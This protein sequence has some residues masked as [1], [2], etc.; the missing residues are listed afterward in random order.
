MSQPTEAAVLDALRTVQDPDLHKDVVSLGFVQD[1][2]IQDG[3]VSFRLVLT[4]PA[5]PVKDQMRKQ[6]EEAV[7]S[8]PGVRK[9]T[10][11]MDS[12]VRSSLQPG[13]I[14]G[15]EVKNVI[16]VTSGKGGVGK[17]TVAVNLAAAL[18]SKGAR[19]GLLDADV[20]GP[21][22]PVMMGIHDKPRGAGNGKI[23][24]LVA[25]GI[26]TMSIGYL[27]EDGQPVMWRGPM[28]HKALEQF[29]KD[30]AW[31]P[32]DYLLV[33][34]PPGTGD[35]QISLA[36]LVPLTGAVVVTMPQEVSLTD[37][38]RAISMARQVRCE[39]LGVVENMSGEVFGRGG[40]RK[41]AETYQVP[42]LGEIPLDPTVRVA[43]DQGVPAV[44]A[45]PDGP[46]ARAFQEV[47]GRLAAAVA[48]RQARSLPV[49]Q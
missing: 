39:I 46:V 23:A 15:D 20:Y 47:A 27:L 17:S 2:R 3:E 9:V 6:A 8:L 34:M 45:R 41:V 49:L 48:T 44:I 16:A 30:V 19:V 28:L 7:A 29:L 32:L 43:G 38:R 36:Q 26:E 18:A 31:G 35:A 22:I 11:D 21:N 12:Q 24:P 14:L 42:F 4:T 1:L 13:N 10:V 37:V 25:H 40:G 5:C 33:D